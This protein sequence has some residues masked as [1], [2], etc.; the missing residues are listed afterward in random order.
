MSNIKILCDTINDVP[1]DVIEKYDIEV[2]PTSIIFEDKEYKAGVDLDGDDF[3]KLLKSSSTIPS[4]AQIPFVVYKEVFEKYVN[5]GK[6]IL[7]LVGS[8]AASGTYQTAT[9]AKNDIENGD[10][11]LVDTY[12]L[13]IGGGML[14][15]E[16]GS[17]VES[18]MDIDEIINKIESYKDKVHV[19]FSVNSLDHLCK[20]GRISGAKAAIGTILNIVPILKIEDGL[21]KQ[22]T[23][24][25]GSKKVMDSL[26]TQL[27]NDVGDDFSNKDVYIGYGDD[28]SQ[29]EDLANKVK[30]QLN[31]RNIFFIQ[32]GSCVACHS[33]PSVLGLACLDI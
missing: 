13:S 27:R 24:V 28:L 14:I 26:I 1:R 31:P 19:Y 2:L 12:S 29:G 8:S 33:G 9:L 7:Y 23:Q 25:R 30:V 32:I 18:G 16:V 4:T 3:Y 20:G 21:V 15:K 6:T 10:I 11:R 5:E 22:R 17:M